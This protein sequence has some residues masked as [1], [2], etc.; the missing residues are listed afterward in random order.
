[1]KQKLISF[2][3]E[4]S[5]GSS[6]LPVRFPSLILF[7]A[8]DFV[9][10]LIPNLSSCYIQSGIVAGER[11]AESRDIVAKYPDRVPVRTNPSLPRLL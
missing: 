9:S 7:G 2:K 3:D 11:L 8:L 6:F 1:M 5:F 4:F 10:F